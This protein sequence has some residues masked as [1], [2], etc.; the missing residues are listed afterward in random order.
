[1]HFSSIVRDLLFGRAATDYREVIHDSINVS[2][3]SI[4][5]ARKARKDTEELRKV[6]E[7]AIRRIEKSHKT[8]DT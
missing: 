3:R 8:N 7:C 2:Q 6:A 1:V 4:A 5:E